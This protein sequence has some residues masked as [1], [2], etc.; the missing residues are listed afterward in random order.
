MMEE[1]LI[2]TFGFHSPSVMVLSSF[3]G[4]SLW[5][6]ADRIQAESSDLI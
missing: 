2:S 5:D 3:S 4:S 6:G 1:E